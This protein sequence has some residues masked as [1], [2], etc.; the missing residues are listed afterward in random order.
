MTGF[1][2]SATYIR[3]S[4]NYVCN[5]LF[6]SFELPR[7]CVHM[8]CNISNNRLC[9]HM[10]CGVF[11]GICA[12]VNCANRD[13]A[14]ISATN[15]YIEDDEPDIKMNAQQCIVTLHDECDPFD[16]MPLHQSVTLDRL[17]GITD[18]DHIVSQPRGVNPYA[19]VDLQKVSILHT[20][21]CMYIT[22][23]EYIRKYVL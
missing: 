9:T 16:L 12:H 15:A 1:C 21:L 19:V 7:I 10:N 6:C 23:V 17:S 22:Y 5:N 2:G 8:N 13:T 20:R 4:Y 3:R 11:N 14:V 18:N